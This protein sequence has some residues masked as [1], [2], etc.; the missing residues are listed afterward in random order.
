MS[1]PP[2]FDLVPE[3]CQTYHG[4]Y[5]IA[6]RNASAEPDGSWRWQV[7]TE[8]HLTPIGYVQSHNCGRYGAPQLMVFDEDNT[9]IGKP[10]AL[11]FCA[12]DYDTALSWLVAAWGPD[13]AE[14]RV[15]RPEWQRP[16]LT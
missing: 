1:T 9:V 15:Q 8:G 10:G 14:L 2:E 16:P 4:F 12:A 5:Y 6:R 11:P 3:T 13:Q 7:F